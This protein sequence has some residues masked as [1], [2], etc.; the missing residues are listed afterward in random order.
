MVSEWHALP[1]GVAYG[2]E[3]GLAGL[4]GPAQTWAEALV[5]ENP[6][7]TAWARYTSG[8]LAG[9]A[10]LS[11]H[12]LGA[13]RAWYLGWYPGMGQAQTLAAHLAE[14]AGIAR[15]AVLPE[16]VV[17]ARRGP[18]TILMNFTDQAQQAAV[19]GEALQVGPRGVRVMRSG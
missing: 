6:A 11:E 16:G 1:P 12:A 10:A 14:K 4:E 5:P 17:A 7:C 19:H 3:T 9:Q 8:P 2:L 13:G 18:F 15:L